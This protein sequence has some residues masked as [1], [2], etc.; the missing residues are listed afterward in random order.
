MDHLKKRIISK[1][2]KKTKQKPKM[3]KLYIYKKI[4][5]TS[6]KKIPYLTEIFTSPD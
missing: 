2:K 1:K 3:I 5:I 4:E 6:I